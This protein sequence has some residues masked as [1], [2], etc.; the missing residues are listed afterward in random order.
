MM[1]IHDLS[2]SYGEIPALRKIS[3]EIKDGESFGL[4]GTNGAGKSTLLRILAGIYRPDTGYVE[5]DGETLRDNAAVRENIFYV[6]DEQ[7]FFPNATSEEVAAYYAKFYPNFDKTGFSRRTKEFGL[8]PKRRVRTY[9]K[10][11]K[12]QLSMITALCSGA[13]YL[14]FDETFDGLDPVSRQAMKSLLAEQLLNRSVTPVF[15]S[16]NLRELEDICDHIG[17][18]HKGGIL[19]SENLEDLKL[20]L[21]KFQYVLPEGADR[22]DIDRLRILSKSVTGRL[23]T[24]VVRGDA[25]EI[26]AVLRAANPV[27]EERIPLTLEEIFISETEVAGYDIKTLVL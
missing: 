27:F 9:S 5:V 18:L 1:E 16:H 14:L 19:L 23:E 7:F 6:S 2:K 22:T 10:G 8:D 21:H 4:I 25:E 3:L 20:N 17:L 26:E 24:I 15:A 11:M 12:K 13:K